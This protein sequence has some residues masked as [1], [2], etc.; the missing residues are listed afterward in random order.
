MGKPSNFIMNLFCDWKDKLLYAVSAL[1]VRRNRIC[2]MVSIPFW[3]KYSAI[4][5]GFSSNYKQ[6]KYVISFI[7]TWKNYFL[8]I[9]DKY[10]PAITLLSLSRIP[11]NLIFKKSRLQFI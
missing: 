11:N 3:C 10:L 4:L 2:I 7:P 6:M 5:G 8:L 9:S 1:L